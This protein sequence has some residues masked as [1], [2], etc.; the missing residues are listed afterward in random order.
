MKN[1]THS[2]FLRTSF[3]PIRLN[4][5]KSR[6]W[7]R[8]SLLCDEAG[9]IRTFAIA[10]FK[11]TGYSEKLDTIH[12]KIIDGYLIGDTVKNS[13]AQ[14][15][16]RSLM[17]FNISLA[18]TRENQTTHFINAKGQLLNIYVRFSRKRAEFYCK[19]CEIYHPEINPFSNARYK[20][21]ETDLIN[22]MLQFAEIEIIN[23]SYEDI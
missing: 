20:K 15:I 2:D 14:L 10:F 21:N 6:G 7:N 11:H 16:R 18:Y 5:I 13:G 12:H 9:T 8:F 17:K 23:I 3:G 19:L 4:I 1:Q 22:N